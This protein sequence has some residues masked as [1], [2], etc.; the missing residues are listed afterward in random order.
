MRIIDRIERDGAFLFRWRSYGPLVLIP[1]LIVALLE[2]ADIEA[3]VGDAW[4]DYW[5]VFCYGIALIGLAIRCAVVAQSAPGTSGRNV[6]EQRA[7]ALNVT[8]LYSVVRHPL[9]LGNFLGLIGVALAPMVWWLALL[10]ALAYWLYIE[11][12]M[13]AEEKYLIGKFGEAYESWAE[14]TPAFIPKPSLWRP[15]DRPVAIRTVLK[16]EY[17]GLL[18][19]ALA[20]AV[21]EFVQDVLVAGETVLAWAQDDKFWLIVLAVSLAVFAVLRTLK[22]KTGILNIVG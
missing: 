19:I 7:D 5:G 13:A 1:V 6:A 4:H 2:A 15:S 12:I 20:F 11:R 22:K 8:G 10:A 17:N 9:Y 3:S 14:S 21:L 18:A 16:R